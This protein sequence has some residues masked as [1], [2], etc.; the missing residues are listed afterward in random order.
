LAMTACY[1]ADVD[2]V[3]P[4][5]AILHAAPLSHGSGLYA[6]PHMAQGALHILP[7][8]GGFDPAE[9]LALFA[10]HRGVGCFFAPTMVK[11]LVEH[12][13]A[14]A[15]DPAGFKTCVYGGGP[16]YLE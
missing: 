5:D 15:L 2:A 10:A 13:D 6:V 1:F 8:S 16:M 7:E 3:A 12:P 14:G 9:V 4:E 11:R